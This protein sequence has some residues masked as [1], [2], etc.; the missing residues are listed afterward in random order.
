VGPDG[1]LVTQADRQP[2]AGFLPT[3]YWPPRQQIVDTYTV[4]LPPDAP[5]GDYRLFVGWY[6]LATLTR[7]PMTQAGQPIGDAYPVAT[8]TV[9]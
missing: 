4:Q 3:S 9:R 6:D 8:F 1:A 5:A 7:L 2:M